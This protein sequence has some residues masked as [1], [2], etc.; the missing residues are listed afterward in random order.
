M[1]AVT[2]PATLARASVDVWDET[3]KG[4]HAGGD[5]SERRRT[6]QDNEATPGAGESRPRGH[7]QPETANIKGGAHGRLENL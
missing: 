4:N 1:E 6:T 2:R 5:A 3:A 7:R